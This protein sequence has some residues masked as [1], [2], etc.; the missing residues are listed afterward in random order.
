MDINIGAT[1]SGQCF[2]V[3]AKSRLINIKL[4]TKTHIVAEYDRNKQRGICVSK[5]KSRMV[6]LI[7]C[8]YVYIYI[9][10]YRQVSN[11]RPTKSQNLNVSCIVLMLSFAIH[12]DQVLSREW[13]YRRYSWSSA[14]RRC[15][16]Y[17]WVIDNSVAYLC[18]TYVRDFTVYIYL[19][20]YVRRRVKLV[21]IWLGPVWF[22]LR[23]CL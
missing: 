10:I 9:Y 6:V 2:A 15:S 14:D 8:M 4:K 11:I 17:I 5:S 1:N 3:C 12:W 16:N 18:A 19:L 22:R 21:G 23:Y 20:F 7:I 13:R